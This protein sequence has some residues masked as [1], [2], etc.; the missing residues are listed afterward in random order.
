MVAMAITVGVVMCLVVL[1]HGD[2]GA[3]QCGSSGTVGGVST[4]K[5]FFIIL[6]IADPMNQPTGILK[7]TGVCW[8]WQ[9]SPVLVVIPQKCYKF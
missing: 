2:R 9:I 6:R 1:V 3:D 4:S 5:S 7:G 8:I